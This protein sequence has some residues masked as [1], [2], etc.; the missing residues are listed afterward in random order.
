[1]NDD[2]PISNDIYIIMR[3]FCKAINMEETHNIVSTYRVT[4][5]RP[6]NCTVFDGTVPYFEPCTV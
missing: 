3:T 6:A 1:M 5:N 2:C 4:V